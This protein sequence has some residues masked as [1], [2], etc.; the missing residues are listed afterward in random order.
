MHLPPEVWDEILVHGGPLGLVRD[1]RHVAARRV[2]RAWRGRLFK[3]GT[4][5]WVHLV[6]LNGPRPGVVCYH[7]EWEQRRACVR[8]LDKKSAFM[9]FPHPSARVSR[10]QSS[11]KSGSSSSS[12]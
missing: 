3:P 11:W 10:S 6:G 8:L 2:Q 4:R 1:A 5:V 12:S 7:C 9:F